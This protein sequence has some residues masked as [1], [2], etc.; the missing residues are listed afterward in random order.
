M[1]QERAASAAGVDGL[2]GREA[3]ELAN[4]VFFGEQPVWEL[5][6]DPADVTRYL[7]SYAAI[8]KTDGQPLLARSTTPLRSVV[9]SGSQAPVSLELERRGDAVVAENPVAPIQISTDP[10]EGVAVAGGITVRA[11]DPDGGQAPVID[12]D[13]VLFANVDPDVDL[14]ASAVPAGGAEFSWLLRTPDAA[15]QYLDLALPAG[16]T[17]TGKDGG[18]RVISAAGAVIAT[19]SRP[20]AIDADGTAVTSTMSVQGTRL[21]VH[22]QTQG[23]DVRWPVL[24]DPAVIPA[25]FGSS[26]PYS[27]AW[28]HWER[29]ESCT[30]AACGPTA[31]RFSR[32]DG[33]PLGVTLNPGTGYSG[34]LYGWKYKAPGSAASGAFVAQ[35]DAGGLS[36]FQQSQSALFA[37]IYETDPGGAPDGA[38]NQWTHDAGAGA[39]GSGQLYTL[40][41]RSSAGLRICTNA[42]T[43]TPF[44]CDTQSDWSSPAHG[45]EGNIVGF[46]L[47]NFSSTLTDPNGFSIGN[48]QLLFGQRTVPYD[49]TTNIPS[50]WV[51]SFPALNLTAQDQGL[52]VYEY[53]LNVNGTTVAVPSPCNG[54]DANSTNYRPCPTTG[55][56]SVPNTNNT[57]FPEGTNQ[58]QIAPKNIFSKPGTT[59]THTLKIDRTAPTVSVTGQLRTLTQDESG[60]DLFPLR[61]E[62]RDGDPN[63][64]PSARRSGVKSIRVTVDGVE[65]P[66]DLQRGACGADS[67]PLSADYELDTDDFGEGSHTV[68]VEVRDYLNQLFADQWTIRVVRD[69]YYEQ[70][71]ASWE[72]STE[73]RVDRANPLPLTGPIPKAPR[74]WRSPAICEATEDALRGCYEANQRWDD[75]IR[76][77][78][79]M[80]PMVSEAPSSLPAPPVYEYARAFTSITLTR[81]MSAVFQTMARSASDPLA[82]VRVAI[83]FHKPMTK[84]DVLGALPGLVDAQADVYLR[85]I[86]DPAGSAIAA[87]YRGRLP[88]LLD[89]HIDAFY[90]DQLKQSTEDI[91]DFE[92]ELR[93]EI[94]GD[95]GDAGE[96]T[97]LS[98]ALAGE[99]DLR[100]ALDAQGP[101]VSSL[102]ANLS[103]TTLTT[104]LTQPNTPIRQ[105]AVLSSSLTD[106]GPLD[107]MT[108]NAETIANGGTAPRSRTTSTSTST[109]TAARASSSNETCDTRNHDTD[110]NKSE[111]WAPGR[112]SAKV[113][114]F[115]G[116]RGDGL[117]LKR[118][119][120]G[121]RWNSSF[122]LSWFCGDD[123]RDRGFEPET[124]VGSFDPERPV[125]S[126]DQVDDRWKSNLPDRYLDD[127]NAATEG[128]FTKDKYPD[129]AVGSANGRALRYN[130]LYYTRNI[131]DYGGTDSGEVVVRVQQQ[132]RPGFRPGQQTYCTGRGRSDSSC[133][134]RGSTCLVQRMPIRQRARRFSRFWSLDSE[135]RAR[136]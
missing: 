8:I 132:K 69:S 32:Q 74:G 20:V 121:L 127:L 70:R 4:E 57:V 76:R 109:T 96:Q 43:G 25:R 39:M 83:G 50:G 41:A 6:Y 30:G 117:H 108:T 114:L 36:H 78:L 54:Y 13:R 19:V 116:A 18:A 59:S 45:R 55:E 106:N 68:R 29:F 7:S 129:F 26:N 44:T 125:W 90:A 46:G 66:I 104:A 113:G 89:D 65:Q 115:E 72:S 119:N 75:E 84:T 102:V 52:G 100:A 28:P 47:H 3:M 88:L 135:E 42:L 122:G 63:G 82:V 134:F 81:T 107:G 35:A 21:R 136:C 93:G 67:C 10:G 105:L 103:V 99:R 1:R 77:W 130:R 80:N 12:G 92:A 23:R 60:Q 79:E 86:H 133:L 22:T 51:N 128:G 87:G 73:S 11:T 111:N 124:K 33:G 48:M 49:L 27:N 110:S 15:D 2:D 112:I 91:A 34:N 101:L 5:P 94:D 16:A 95:A 71:L 98:E 37:G 40:D 118:A 64:P 85:G 17:V 120:M 9:G 14:I 62:A 97:A 123:P 58:L 38:R 31:N 126:S 56:T 53:E 131:T 61:I 24:V